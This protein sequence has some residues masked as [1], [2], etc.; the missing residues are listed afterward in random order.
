MNQTTQMQEQ[1]RD[2]TASNILKTSIPR[3]RRGRGRKS[4]S[5]PNVLKA[6]TGSKR[7]RKVAAGETDDDGDENVKRLKLEDGTSTMHDNPEALL[8]FRQPDAI[9][10]AK[11]KDYQLVGVQWLTSLWANG[12]NGILADEMGLGYVTLLIPHILL[13]YTPSALISIQKSKSTFIMM[14]YLPG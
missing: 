7:P 2:T 11:L 6:K 14:Y 1:S 4:E 10:G 12:V 3:S 9:T 5:E 8:R 13:S